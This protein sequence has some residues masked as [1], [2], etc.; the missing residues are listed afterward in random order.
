MC[1]G[2]PPRFIH[3][4]APP[5]IPLPLS[6]PPLNLNAPCRF[7]HQTA[8]V[9]PLPPPLANLSASWAA[10]N[11]EWRIRLWDDKAAA[12]FVASEV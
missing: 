1:G 9:L 12:A 7:I 4:T 3:Q 5:F 11:P 2:F 10:L 6:G 8:P